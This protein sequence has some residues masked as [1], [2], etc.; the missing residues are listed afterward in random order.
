M[1]GISFAQDYRYR[2]E[3]RNQNF[4]QF[5]SMRLASH[6]RAVERIRAAVMSAHPRTRVVD[7]H[8]ITQPLWD[9]TWDGCH[10][11]RNGGGDNND[12]KGAGF[13]CQW[14]GGASFMATYMLVQSLCAG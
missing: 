7:L 4:A 10:Y 9:A 5:R 13:T 12:W 6:G 2:H 1:T 8:T 11:A 14:Q 3:A